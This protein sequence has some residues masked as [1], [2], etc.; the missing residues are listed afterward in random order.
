MVPT[1]AKMKRYSFKA[2]LHPSQLLPSAQL[3]SKI[4][5][6][7]HCIQASY[8]D[9]RYALDSLSQRVMAMETQIGILT[10]YSPQNSDE[11]THNLKDLIDERTYQRLIA[12]KSGNATISPVGPGQ[13]A[14]SSESGLQ[15]TVPTTRLF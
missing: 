13:V 3:E 8:Y 5:A 12:L 14:L 10:C 11:S 7:Y 15:A 9:L 6:T 2:G 4:E 1:Q